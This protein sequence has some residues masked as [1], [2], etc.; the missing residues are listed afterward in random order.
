[1]QYDKINTKTQ[2]SQYDEHVAISIIKKC[3]K[4][5]TQSV[6]LAQLL[7]TQYMAGHYAIMSYL[8]GRV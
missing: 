8:K 3:Y 5:S 6:A 1:M 4:M 7:M 2:H